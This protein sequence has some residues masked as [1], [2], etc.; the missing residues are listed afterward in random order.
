MTSRSVNGREGRTLFQKVPAPRFPS[1]R[2]TLISSSTA[3]H[4]TLSP[5]LFFFLFFLL[6]KCREREREGRMFEF[7]IQSFRNSVDGE[8]LLRRFLRNYGFGV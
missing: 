5:V 8:M 7:R 6:E 4:C 1:F 3:T 2:T